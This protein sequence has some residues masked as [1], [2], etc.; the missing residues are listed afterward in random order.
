MKKH[1]LSL[2]SCSRKSICFEE[3]AY[4]LTPI[5]ELLIERKK[6]KFREKTYMYTL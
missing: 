4:F 3:N 2:M 1:H 5:Q 6:L